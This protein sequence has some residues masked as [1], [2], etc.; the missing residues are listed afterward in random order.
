MLTTKV[1]AIRRSPDM[2]V[3]ESVESRIRSHCRTRDAAFDRAAGGTIHCEDGLENRD[4]FSGARG[5]DY[6]HN[7][8]VLLLP[9]VEYLL[10]RAIVHSLDMETH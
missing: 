2:D 1:K 9:P 7:N 8:P 10:S 6:G 4:H 5:L 3:F